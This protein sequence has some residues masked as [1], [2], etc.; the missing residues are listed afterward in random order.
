MKQ[1]TFERLVRSGER[2]GVIRYYRGAFSALA[3]AVLAL[4]VVVPALAQDAPDESPEH[5]VIKP[6]IGATLIEEA[7]RADD[8][9]QMQVRYRLDGR[10]IDETVEGTFWHLEYQLEDRGTSRDEIMANY[11]AEL[12]R[13]GG[14]VLG[15]SG[16]R[17]RFRIVS[18]GGARPGP[19]WIRVRTARMNSTSSTRPDST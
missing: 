13:V 3:A 4:A 10:T 19:S 7:S 1:K 16:T 8:F 15:R 18:R 12:E 11:A 2:A 9:G 6:M 5:P 17:L 14:E